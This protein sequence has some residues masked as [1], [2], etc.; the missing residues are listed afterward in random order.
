MASNQRARRFNFT[1]PSVA[2]LE[3]PPGRDR[4]YH[5]DLKVPGLAVQV[6][7]SGRKVFYRV[8]RIDGRPVRY[9]LGVFPAI[10][11]DTARSLC[12]QANGEIAQGK[13]PHRTRRIKRQEATL[14]DLFQWWFKQHSEPLKRTSAS[15]Q[16]YYDNFLKPWATRRLSTIS[17]A[18]VTEWHRR[19]GRERGQHLANRAR[20]L[21][22]TLFN[23][24]DELGF[25][26]VNPC[27]G[28]KRFKEAP[29]ER[30][31]QP[32]E[33]PAF[34]AAVNAEPSEQVRHAILLLLLTGQRKSNVL[35]M[36]WSDIDLSQSLWRIPPEAAKSGKTILV[37]LA[38]PA[39]A[40]LQERF[41]TRGDSPWVFPAG[42]RSGRFE[43]LKSGWKRILDRAG[44]ADIRVHD[45]R[46]TVGSW[47]AIGGA[48]I[49][50]IGKVLGHTSL[51]ATQIYAR[52]S[53]DAA[54]AAVDD[55]TQRLLAA[56]KPPD[57]E[58]RHGKKKAT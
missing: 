43:N 5:Y 47:L 2:T 1:Q 19:I 45:L 20:G 31:L 15:D 57:K 10:T 9:K 38:E 42:T 17:K 49:A 51:A 6:S 18:D 13:D 16:W 48:N 7:Q 32:S 39:L 37:H 25:N 56:A 26:G 23:R 53:H 29:R 33:L 30:F 12:A 50:T 44:L 40:V 27:F 35:A 55:V 36:Q 54:A 21:L 4:I 34:F 14:G 41:A 58:A 22:S 46:R 52:L 28:V 24:A 11:V 8:G 3:P